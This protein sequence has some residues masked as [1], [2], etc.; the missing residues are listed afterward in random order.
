MTCE[1]SSELVADLK[2]GEK[3]ESTCQSSLSS[4]LSDQVPSQEVSEM[5]M[6]NTVPSKQD[7]YHQYDKNAMKE[8]SKA[9]GNA[10]LTLQP[11]FK[12]ILRGSKSEDFIF[13]ATNPSGAQGRAYSGQMRSQQHPQS[14]KQYRR[15]EE[16]HWGGQHPDQHKLEI[17]KVVN[18]LRAD[19][20]SD[21][22]ALRGLLNKLTPNNFEK[23]VS[24]INENL[25][26]EN[27]KKFVELVFDKAVSE[28][29]FCVIYSKMCDSC[30]NKDDVEKKKF[31]KTLLNH[32]QVEFESGKEAFM[33]QAKELSEEEKSKDEHYKLNLARRRRFTGLMNFVGMLYIV[34]LCSPTIIRSCVMLLLGEAGSHPLPEDV[35]CCSKLIGAIGG[36]L[37]KQKPQRSDKSKSKKTFSMDVAKEEGVFGLFILKLVEDRFIALIEEKKEDGRYFYE[38]RVRFLMQ[39]TLDL[40]ADNWKVDVEGP[41]KIEEIHKEAA[42]LRRDTEEK[43]KREREREREQVKHSSRSGGR[44]SYVN[45]NNDYNRRAPVSRM[46]KSDVVP[47]SALID[48]PQV[49]VRTNILSRDT[50]KPH[51]DSQTNEVKNSPPP[52]PPPSIDAKAVGKSIHT[53]L[54]VE[55]DIDHVCSMLG[56]IKLDGDISKVLVEVFKQALETRNISDV[57]ERFGPLGEFLLDVALPDLSVTLENAVCNTVADKTVVDEIPSPKSDTVDEG[58]SAADVTIPVE[59]PSLPFK[60]SEI[61]S[62]FVEETLEEIVVAS[63]EK[64]QKE[65]IAV[66]SDVSVK[67]EDA[68][69]SNETMG[70]VPSKSESAPE[71]KPASKFT[72]NLGAQK[73]VLNPTPNTTSSHS[74][75]A[76]K[77]NA[78]TLS[79][80]VQTGQKADIKD[81]SSGEQTVDAAVNKP[82]PDVQAQV[83][84]NEEVVKEAEVKDKEVKDEEVKDEEVKDEEEVKEEQNVIQK[85]PER[86]VVVSV[87]ALN[88]ALFSFLKKDLVALDEENPRA[89]AALG[90]L[91]GPLILAKYVDFKSVFE[92]ALEK[93]EDEEVSIL[94]ELDIASRILQ[95]TLL[96]IAKSTD[97]TE[98]QNIWAT[99]GLDLASLLS[100]G[101]ADVK[102]FLEYVPFLEAVIK[103]ETA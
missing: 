44:D 22:K 17:S 75:V 46:H 21:D 88:D 45:F 98:A 78:A 57:T 6:D 42:Q 31:R 89:A 39:D 11:E 90:K 23:L 91:L 96:K 82:V 100:N 2:G 86:M 1:S 70:E 56:N 14:Q 27:M 13:G 79:S 65:E 5:C 59:A 16:R 60:F 53:C 62:Q 74:S 92:A 71:P 19:R 50:S 66:A 63:S 35:E 51:S 73:F 54:Y 84:S 95:S 93:L 15:D 26:E 61:V 68:V 101:E 87:K 8:I 40:K 97:S 85:K 7:S 25:K 83:A 58:S 37:S 55:K 9:V 103:K 99:S 34:G 67:K 52:P 4:E 29:T 32:C 49:P 76:K 18:Q 12:S 33:N 80:K 3:D 36:A 102:K 72:W 64:E 20:G 69:T 38:P 30:Y 10:T 77:E 28:P 41:Q 43:D 81:Q 94:V 47:Y 48:N 24:K